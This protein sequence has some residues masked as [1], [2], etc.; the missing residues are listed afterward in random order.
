M[1]TPFQPPDWMPLERALEAELGSEARE[2]TNAFSFVRF[3]DGP[4]D[5]G[6]LRVYEHNATHRQLTLDDHGR[7]YRFFADMNK[8]GSLGAGS[9]LLS[10]LAG[11]A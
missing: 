4:A 3:V 11:R 7:A 9:A 8:Y 10:A 6:A 1:H 5:V 2:L